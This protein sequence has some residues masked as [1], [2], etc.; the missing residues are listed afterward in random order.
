MP[1]I[2]Q[3][4]TLLAQSYAFQGLALAEALKLTGDE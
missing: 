1:P 3:K 4:I 2:Q